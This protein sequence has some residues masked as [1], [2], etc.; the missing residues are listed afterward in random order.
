VLIASFIEYNNCF[1]H[2]ALLQENIYFELKFS[3]ESI[4]QILKNKVACGILKDFCRLKN[5]INQRFCA[6]LWR[7]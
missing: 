7:L 5:K 3:P 6:Y 1:A 2:T 4:Q